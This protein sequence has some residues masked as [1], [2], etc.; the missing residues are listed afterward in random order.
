MRSSRAAATRSTSS[1]PSTSRSSITPTLE[2]DGDGAIRPAGSREVLGNMD[3]VMT[4]RVFAAN[5]PW[6]TR[7]TRRDPRGDA[8][9]APAPAAR[10]GLLPRRCSV[11]LPA[12]SSRT[13]EIADNPHRWEGMA[14]VA[15]VDDRVVLTY[16]VPGHYDRDTTPKSSRS[17]REG[18]TF[19]ADFVGRARGGADLRRARVPALPRRY[20]A[21]RRAADDA[22]PRARPLRA[23]GSTAMC[24]AGR[25]RARPRTDRADRAR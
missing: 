10:G 5:G 14:D 24:A 21:L 6:I 2:V 7:A 8:A 23:A 16:A 17:S 18:V 15:V 1:R 11:S 9:H 25:A 22:A 4:G 3:D 19:A 20:R 13:L 12:R